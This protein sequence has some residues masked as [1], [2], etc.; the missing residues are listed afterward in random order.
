MSQCASP[1]FSIRH[2]PALV[3]VSVS[4]AVLA[5]YMSLEPAGRMRAS[6]GWVRWLWRMPLVEASGRC[7]SSECWRT[8]STNRQCS[9][10]ALRTRSGYVGG[11][12]S[13]RR[14]DR[15][16][17][18]RRA[19]YWYGSA[20]N[21]CR[22]ELRAS[23]G[24]RICGDCNRGFNGCALARFH[25]SKAII[26]LCRMLRSGIENRPAVLPASFKLSIKDTPVY[27]VVSTVVRIVDMRSNISRRTNSSIYDPA[28]VPDL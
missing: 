15:D 9:N 27:G 13:W 17:Y 10:P 25:F 16:G 11:G 22:R 20:G 23:V 18:C 2:D 5:G 12:C 19:L 3:I 7:F 26:R 21:T 1:I 4:V 24:G 14:G 28:L 6:T 8:R